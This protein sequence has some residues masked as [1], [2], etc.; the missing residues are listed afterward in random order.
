MNSFIDP[1][2]IDKEMSSI[3][4]TFEDL[5]K[6]LGMDMTDELIQ[7]FLPTL[8]ECLTNLGP[9]IE[10]GEGEPVVVCAHKLKGAAAQMGA[11]ALADLCK[12]VE[13]T[14]RDNQ[15]ADAW[16]LHAQILALG[17]AVGQRLRSGA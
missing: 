14:G 7:L 1:E 8:D 5:K 13:Q 15:L 3:Y 11:L 12:K 6:M 4:Q 16:P 10:A 2:S 17:G 9:L